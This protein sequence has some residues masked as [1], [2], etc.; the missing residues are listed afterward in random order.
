MGV[1]HGARPLL[2][3]ASGAAQVQAGTLVEQAF[4]EM[5]GADREA[6]RQAGRDSFVCER[7]GGQV[8][9]SRRAAHMEHWCP[10]IR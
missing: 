10:G 5:G 1:A 2:S 6:L 3:T 4:A 8:A 7:C 9:L